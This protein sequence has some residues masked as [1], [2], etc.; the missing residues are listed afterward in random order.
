L[1]DKLQ[2]LV[3]V[4]MYLSRLNLTVKNGCTPVLP[5]LGAPPQPYIK[6][7]GGKCLTHIDTEG[8]ATTAS[9]WIPQ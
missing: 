4:E 2:V 6:L 9:G 7:F 1:V 5:Q 3:L 8:P